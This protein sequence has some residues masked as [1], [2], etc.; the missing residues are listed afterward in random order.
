MICHSMHI[1]SE[2]A[3]A[4]EAFQDKDILLHTKSCAGHLDIADLA[5]AGSAVHTCH[6]VV[7]SGYPVQAAIGTCCRRST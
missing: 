5:C 4:A 1:A 6:A 2:P 3:L 7:V